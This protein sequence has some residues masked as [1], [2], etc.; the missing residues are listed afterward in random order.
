MGEVDDLIS[1]ERYSENGYEVVEGTVP[2]S[3]GREGLL[4]VYDGGSD[5]LLLNNNLEWYDEETRDWIAD[6]YSPGEIRTVEPEHC[7]SASVEVLT[8][9]YLGTQE[10]VDV[11]EKLTRLSWM[12]EDPEEADETEFPTSRN[13]TREGRHI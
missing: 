4:A 11:D 2:R 10:E 12:G 3:G 5:V 6:V 1:V 8:D 9:M 13:Y 7:S